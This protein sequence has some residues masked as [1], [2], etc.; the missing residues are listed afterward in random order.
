[1]SYFSMENIHCFRSYSLFCC[2][3]IFD[4]ISSLVWNIPI[5]MM[6]LL[7][8][9]TFHALVEIEFTLPFTLYRVH[10]ITI[11]LASNALKFYEFLT[12]FP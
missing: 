5:F 12:V 4:V 7:T 11:S 6:V 1:M 8:K 2:A 9:L 3:N 10:L